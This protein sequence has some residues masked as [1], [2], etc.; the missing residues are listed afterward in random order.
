MKKSYE[1]AKDRNI[2]MRTLYGTY[3]ITREWSFETTEPD[4]NTYKINNSENTL[5]SNVLE[6]T[7]PIYAEIN[8]LIQ[9]NSGSYS[10]FNGSPLSYGKFQF[11]D[12]PKPLWTTHSVIQP[13]TLC[14]TP[15]RSSL[16]MDVWLRQKAKL[17]R[18]RIESAVTRDT[19]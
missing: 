4:C 7:K 18:A 1:I 2:A 11:E 13:R 16:Q 5:I 3:K 9:D 15:G 14:A 12:P 19:R 6:H 8:N 10:S 17:A